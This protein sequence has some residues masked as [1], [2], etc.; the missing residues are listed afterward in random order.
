MGPIWVRPRPGPEKGEESRAFAFWSQQRPPAAAG[1]VSF[2]S[3][4]PPP[5]DQPR[6]CLLRPWN[7]TRRRDWEANPRHT[8]LPLS[9]SLS[10]ADVLCASLSPSVVGRWLGSAWIRR[11]RRRRSR[12]ARRRRL[13]CWTARPSPATTATSASPP[14]TP[15]AP[16]SPRRCSTARPLSPF[17]YPV[18]PLSYSLRLAWALTSQEGKGLPNCWFG[19]DR[20]WLILRDPDF[21]IVIE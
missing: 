1:F 18:A 3:P 6:R 21:L 15:S 4:P 11:R 14:S 13:R 16:A 8:V 2:L 7:T 20:T 19:F 9:L 12:C 10:P 5:P 17:P